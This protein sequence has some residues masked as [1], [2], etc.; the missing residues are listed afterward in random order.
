MLDTGTNFWSFF[1]RPRRNIS[2]HTDAHNECPHNLPSFIRLAHSWLWLMLL[3]TLERRK[4]PIGFM[5]N[6]EFSDG[7][8]TARFLLLLG[9]VQ[10]KNTA[11]VEPCLINLISN[12]KLLWS[13]TLEYQW[14]DSL[15]P[16][17]YRFI[18]TSPFLAT[19][20]HI[21][22]CFTPSP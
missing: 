2:S 9:I 20:V 18:M 8:A 17:Y 1:Y 15:Q 4:G 14:S 7:F 16:L 13:I 19:I 6:A 22:Y 21:L 5:K 11:L 12:F 3:S 10:R